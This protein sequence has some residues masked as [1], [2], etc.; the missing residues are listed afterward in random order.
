MTEMGS[1]NEKFTFYDMTLQGVVITGHK[2]FVLILFSI[3]VQ[4]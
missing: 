2:Q 3:F 1:G 4:T